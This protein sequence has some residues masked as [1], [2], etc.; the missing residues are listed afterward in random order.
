MTN[1]LL[2]AFDTFSGA[3][4]FVT[5]WTTIIG[6]AEKVLVAAVL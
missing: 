6:D 4:F 5:M 2:I 3:G 1:D